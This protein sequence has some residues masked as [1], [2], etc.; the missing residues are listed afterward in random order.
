MGWKLIETAPKDGTV[1]WVYVAAYSDLPAF[2]CECAYHKDAGWCADELREVT[3][4][5]SLKSKE[6]ED[7]ILKDII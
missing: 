3:H 1:V 4:W 2:E 5:M 7:K 6:Y